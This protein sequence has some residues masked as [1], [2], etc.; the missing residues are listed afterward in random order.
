MRFVMYEIGNIKNEEHKNAFDN[1]LNK[2]KNINED[3]KKY[4]MRFTAIPEMKYLLLVASRPLGVFIVLALKLF[5]DFVSNNIPRLAHT[6]NVKS[7]KVF[8]H[9]TKAQ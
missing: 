8:T 5:L 1:E 9:Y 4:P 3:S 2:S 7:A 6:S